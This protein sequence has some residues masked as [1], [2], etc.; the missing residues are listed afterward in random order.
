MERLFSEIYNRYF[1]IVNRLLIKRGTIS[2]KMM[3]DTV[4]KYGFGESML[5][6]LPE[7]SKNRWEFFEETDGGFRSKLTG[8][9]TAPLS[10]LQKRWLK[11]VLSDPRA[12]LF[13]DEEQKSAISE[14]LQDITPLFQ[15][16]DFRYFDRFSDGDDYADENYREHFRMLRNAIYSKQLLRIHYEARTGRTT[17]LTVYPQY[18]EYSAKNDCYRLL[19]EA[20]VNKR[21]QKHILRISRIKAAEILKGNA[22]A[23]PAHPAEKAPE[24]ITLLIRDQRNAVERIMLQFADYRKNTVR[25]D[26]NSYRC[27]IFYDKDDETELLIEILSFG[28]V[29]QVI[30]NAHFIRLVKERLQR[31]NLMSAVL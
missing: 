26:D 23:E 2:A 28:P 6:L 25:L 9:V 16:E 1:Q 17:K 14:A 4:Q 29:V 20:A 10:R 27:E 5:F 30:E 18:L 13:L 11:A 19:C 22:N 12:A 31:Q 7:L 3:R 21:M 15:Y 24:K 8:G